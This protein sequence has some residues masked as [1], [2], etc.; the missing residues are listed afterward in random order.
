MG[1]KALELLGITK[2]YSMGDN[3]VH[4]LRGITLDV[5]EGEMVSIIG[6]S[7]CGKSTLL[8]IIGCLDK[9]TA[10]LVRIGGNEAC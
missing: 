2:V 3:Q 5:R 8:Q 10:G 6:P 1:N 4:A 9:P 7:G